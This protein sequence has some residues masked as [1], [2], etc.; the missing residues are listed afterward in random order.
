M[1]NM[2]SDTQITDNFKYKEL[3]G[4]R[5]D[6]KPENEEQFCNLLYGAYN[7]LQP[8]RDEFGLIYVSSGRRSLEYNRLIGSK[9]TSQHI[10]GEAYDIF[11][12]YENC[13]KVYKW[14]IDN[15][16][17]DQVIFERRGNAEWIHVS[18][19]RLGKNRKRNLVSLQ[20]CLYVPYNGQ[21]LEKVL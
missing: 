21:C 11:A 14:I 9:D 5:P 3:Y 15:L 13:D 16:E 2:H 20:K 18:F 7:I 8:I 12:K 10:S 4:N 17:Y 6:N 1:F 19:K